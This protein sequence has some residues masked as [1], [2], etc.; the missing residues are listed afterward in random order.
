MNGAAINRPVTI[1][2]HEAVHQLLYDR[3]SNRDRDVILDEGFAT[4]GAGEYWLGGY[5]DFRA[6]HRGEYGDGNFRSLDFSPYTNSDVSTWNQTYYEW[7]SFVEFLIQ[8]PGNR[9]EGLRKFYE[10]YDTDAKTNSPN[11]I[12]PKADYQKVYGKTF[13]EMEAEWR[14]WMVNW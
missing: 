14:A 8:L 2:A 13:Q 6:Y 5:P 1:M 4:W 9:E 3:F 12:F 7:A 11:E 10:L